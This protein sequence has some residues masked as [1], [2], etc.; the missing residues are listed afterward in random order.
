M[1]DFWSTI[2]LSNLESFLI[3]PA[4]ETLGKKQ[5]KNLQKVNNSVAFHAIKEKAFDLLTS[6]ISTKEVLLKLN[7]LF[8][9]NPTQYRTNRNRPRNKSKTK[10]LNYCRYRKK[11]VF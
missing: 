7:E 9:L 8:L 1:Q 11:V 10:S 4:Q 3:H 5:A 6:N 2:F